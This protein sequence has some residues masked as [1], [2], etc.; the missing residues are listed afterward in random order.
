MPKVQHCFVLKPE[1]LFIQSTPGNIYSERGCQSFQLIKSWIQTSIV[2][3][4]QGIKSPLASQ[5]PPRSRRD[6]VSRRLEEDIQAVVLDEALCVL[7]QDG[8]NAH[9]RAAQRQH[10]LRRRPDGERVVGHKGRVL[11]GKRHI[12]APDTPVCRLRVK[13]RR[14]PERRRGIH[15]RDGG[16]GRVLPRVDGMHVGVERRRLVR[17]LPVELDRGV[18]VHHHG[19]LRRAGPP[20]VAAD[21][22]LRAE[23]RPLLDR[24]PLVA[25][26]VPRVLLERRV[27]ERK[28]H[29]HTGLVF[30]GNGVLPARHDGEVLVVRVAVEIAFPACLQAD[31]RRV[32]RLQVQAA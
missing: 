31:A 5:Y 25:A 11:C 17:F 12:V 20:A 4:R 30:K 8:R 28:P 27:V 2:W 23:A 32:V 18:L 19:V 3:N 22:G 10:R 1:R 21:A 7:A 15:V 26:A 6:V 14:V 9:V 29:V 24:L 13:I 16:A